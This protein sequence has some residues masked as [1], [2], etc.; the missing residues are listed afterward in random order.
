MIAQEKS[1]G[2]CSNNVDDIAGTIHTRY[3]VNMKEHNDAELLKPRRRCR[4]DS[5]GN[6]LFECPGCGCLHSVATEKPNGMGAQWT[7]NGSE[8]LPTFSP[9]VLV[10]YDKG[11][12]DKPA[13]DGVCH[14]F[15]KDGMIQFLG[16][17][18]HKLANKTVPLPDWDSDD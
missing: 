7:W 6:V 1:K 9:S 4:R 17:C 16:D 11:V 5:A 3:E 12:S 8:E 2:R 13:L 15:V 14:S 10:R 18:T